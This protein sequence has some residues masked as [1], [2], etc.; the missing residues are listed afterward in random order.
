MIANLD[1]GVISRAPGHHARPSSQ[2][3]TPPYPDV[4]ERALGATRRW[5][6]D[7]QHAD[8]YWVG[9][10]EGDTILESGYILLM[11][12]LGREG[13]PACVKLARYLYEH[14]RPEGG[15]SIYPG[16]PADLSASVKAYLALK[17]VG[18]P[19]SDPILARARQI[20]LEAGGAQECN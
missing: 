15:W 5:L 18:V 10:L 2:A 8:G 7:Q 4:L 16:G 1:G 17:L 9:E 13:E 19:P 3:R 20:I 14:T 6:L 11:A 12:Y